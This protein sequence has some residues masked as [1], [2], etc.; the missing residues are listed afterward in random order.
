[1]DVEP[2]AD[3]RSLTAHAVWN[4]DVPGASQNPASLADQM[5]AGQGEPLSFRTEG[6]VLVA[7]V[8]LP[9][10]VQTAGLLGGQTSIR[11]AVSPRASQ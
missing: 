5:P 9:P 11:L 4:S 8:T 7:S 2:G 10:A 3:N 1:M 6:G